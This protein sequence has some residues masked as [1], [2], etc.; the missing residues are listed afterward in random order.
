MRN[1]INITS[2]IKANRSENVLI[3]SSI[4]GRPG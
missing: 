1:I 4:S 3:T 2:A